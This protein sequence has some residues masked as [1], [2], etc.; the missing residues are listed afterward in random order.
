MRTVIDSNFLQSDGLRA[1]LSKSP[2]NMAVLTDYAAMEAHKADTLEMLYRS[3]AIVAEFPRQVIVLKG[4]L[5]VCALSGR[6]SG[7]QR[8]MIDQQQTRGFPEYCRHLAIARRGDLSLQAQLLELARKSRLQMERIL[9]DVQDFGGAVEEIANLFNNNEIHS[10]RIG[11]PYTPEIVGKMMQQIYTSARVLFARHPRVTKIPPFR[12]LPNTFLFRTALCAHL[13]AKRWISV[14]G[15]HQAKPARIRNDLV[16]V[17]FAVYAT[18]FDAFL[19]ADRKIN[20]L[21]QEMG[22]FLKHVF[23]DLPT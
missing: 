20:E 12:E 4:T 23:S 22:W 9:K 16:D 7:L 10:I 19:T 5:A 6:A 13:L 2:A 21:Y 3:M 17:N 8:R 14:G 18:Y 11:M 15:A 1:Y